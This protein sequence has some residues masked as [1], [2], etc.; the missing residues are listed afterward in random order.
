MQ[1]TPIALHPCHGGGCWRVSMQI[2]PSTLHPC[3]G[4]GCWRVSMQMSYTRV[5]VKL[6]RVGLNLVSW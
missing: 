4:G 6:V 3:H 5:M 1:V 2:T